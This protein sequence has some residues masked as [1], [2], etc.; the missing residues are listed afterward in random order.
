MTTTMLLG[1]RARVPAMEAPRGKSLTPEQNA[2]VREAVRELLPRHGSVITAL[3]KALGITQAGLSSFL[4]GRTGAGLQLAT[5]VARAEGV[6]LNALLDGVADE[7]ASF[8]GQPDAPHNWNLPGYREAEQAARAQH[9]KVPGWAWIKARRHRNVAMPDPITPEAVYDQALIAWKNT[10]DAEA[11]E[12]ERRALES[13]IQR[14]RTRAANRE[15]RP[16]APAS[17]EGGAA[18]APGDAPRRRRKPR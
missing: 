11:V 8:E 9:G 16:E 7:G 17:P 5:A 1:D 4:S 14:V 3:A 13:E 6:S 10:P 2:R 18:V 15:P 12:L